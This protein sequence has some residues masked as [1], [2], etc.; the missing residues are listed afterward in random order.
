MYICIYI[1]GNS[2]QRLYQP[3][4]LKKDKDKGLRLPGLKAYY[5]ATVIKSVIYPLDRQMDQWNRV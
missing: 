2:V 5:K 4:V 3:T 1:Y